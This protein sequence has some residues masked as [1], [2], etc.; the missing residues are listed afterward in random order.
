[1]E[2]R[3]SEN[4]KDHLTHRR[5]PFDDWLRKELST[6]ELLLDDPKLASLR[7][8]RRTH[9]AV[10]RFDRISDILSGI[11]FRFPDNTDLPIAMGSA[12]LDS[13]MLTSDPASLDDSILT[14]IGDE[15]ALRQLRSRATDPNQFADQMTAYH[16][17]SLLRAT[18]YAP[19]L[20]EQE[21]M[22]DISLPIEGLPNLWIECKHVQL[23]TTAIRARKIVK[24]ANQQLKRADSSGAGL[25]F[26]FIERPEYRVAFDDSTP[27]HVAEFISEIKRELSSGHS[28][29]VA[30]V[31]VCWDDYM[32]LGSP[33]ERTAYFFRRRSML[34]A[35]DSPRRNLMLPASLLE[36][37]RT[38]FFAIRWTGGIPSAVKLK[39]VQAGDI[40][41]TQSFRDICEASGDLR[42]DYAIAAAQNPGSEAL[43]GLNGG[44]LVLA[45]KNVAVAASP[46]T[47]LLL[48]A[49]RGEKLHIELGFR[50]YPDLIQGKTPSDPMDLFILIL[51]RFGLPVTVGNQTGHLIPNAVVPVV[52]N[53]PTNFIQSSAA[54][55]ENPLIY[56]IVRIRD[57]TPPVADVKWAF[58]VSRRRYQEYVQRHKK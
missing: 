10:I 30:K 37:G 41:V 28:K 12:L 55:D 17:W 32:V 47:L 7:A 23:A 8:K 6:L 25:L 24:K 27:S 26:V 45:T 13:L 4:D 53:G 35:H 31:M 44:T 18:G 9:P 40:V 29:S 39:P 58:G 48:A 1:M 43:Y 49:I 22:P 19:R 51:N 11:T 50:V 56:G 54:P 20:L 38:A 57:S 15:E 21:G 42:A 34:V 14:E 52:S 36:L 2:D 33:P 16:C 3:E 5:T 46:F